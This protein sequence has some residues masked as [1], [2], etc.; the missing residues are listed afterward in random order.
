MMSHYLTTRQA[1]AY[2]HVGTTSIKRWCDDGQ[3]ECEKTA[4]GH[5]RFSVAVLDRFQR[6]GLPGDSFLTT[7]PFMT[8]QEVDDLDFG[9]VQ[10]DDDGMVLLYS[11]W[12]SRFTGFG[13]ESVEGKSFFGRVA[14][15]T[16]NELVY[17]AFRRGLDSGSLDT[18]IDY[19]FTYKMNPRNVH[20]HLY[21]HTQTKTNWII[22]TKA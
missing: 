11:L 19:T 22:V 16:N 12:E 1:A 3:L 2:L 14:P 20:L 18:E 17:G 21:R 13:V 15:C 10:L 5:R 9:V 6:K 4:G 7:L 8:R